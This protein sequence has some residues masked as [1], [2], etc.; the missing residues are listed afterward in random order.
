MTR[1]TALSATLALTSALLF[2]ASCSEPR[3][4]TPADAG[5]KAIG[6]SCN[7]D[8]ECGGLRCDPIRRQCIC[9]SD[10]DCA[11]LDPTGELIYC[12]N[13]T[14]LCVATVAGC[15][16]DTE[17]PAGSFCDDTVRACKVR[18]AFCE[19]CASD[20]EC[21]SDADDCL[22]DASLKARF[23]GKFC[24]VDTDCPAGAACTDFAGKKQC[25]P[26]AGKNCRIF[27]GCTPDSKASCTVSSDCAAVPDQVCD[28]G[29]GVCVARNQVCPFGQVCD[30]RSRVCVDACASDA[31]CIA[32]DA[33]LRCVNRACE[34]IGECAATATDP[35]GDLSCPANKVCSFNPGQ[36]VGTCVPFCS[37][38]QECPQGQVCTPTADGRRKCQAGCR[39]SADCPLE[40][41][42]VKSAGATIGQC[43]AAGTS[44]CQTDQ[45][46][47]VC[48]TC[49]V[50][51]FSC[52]QRS[53]KSDGYCRVCGN[54]TDC[55]QGHCLTLK[56]GSRCG[57]PCPATG[58]PRG[59][60]CNEICVNGTYQGFKCSGTAYAECIPV[61]QTCLDAA[62]A[63]KCAQ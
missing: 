15:T 14:G 44:T 31:D 16:S 33:K 48:G 28:P 55:G 56:N 58:C 37:S 47:P 9:G 26:K 8:D 62:G 12:N 2:A 6:R 57:Q 43:T 24:T 21:G 3:K 60:V 53:M 30:G 63:E 32:I 40:R 4:N 20:R 46:C 27:M 22:F 52:V 36:T 45:V 7:V 34:P 41:M 49:N 1:R 38:D 11:E 10:E 54:D 35:S 13:F 51:A 18:K 59:F 5:A 23:C 42:C 29:S 25:W 50:Q 17:C 19:P 61:D 39:V